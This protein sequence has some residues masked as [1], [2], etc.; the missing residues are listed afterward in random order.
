MDCK[1]ATL[2]GL[3]AVLLWAT[4]TGTIRG[5][6]EDLGP[7]AGA[8]AIYTL[9]AAILAV[10]VGRPRLAD[11]PPKYLFGAGGCYIL[12]QVCFVLALGF[13]HSGR[14]AIEAAML[15]YLWPSLTV[16]FAVLFLKRR[17]N[18]LIVPGLILAFAGVCW[19][20]SDGQGLL[21]YE[22]LGNVGDN[23]LC[24]G[25]AFVGS[26]FWAGYSTLAVKT[27]GG[28][29]GIALFPLLSAAVLWGLFLL[30]GGPPVRPSLKSVA[31]LCLAAAATGFGGTAWSV[32]IVRGNVMLL[33]V[34]SYF[35]PVLAAAFAAALLGA[36]L[37]APF[38]HGA[39]TVCCGS[40]L[41]WAS[42]RGR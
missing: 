10:A 14:Q 23:P 39:L 26:F 7:I 34:A 41:C 28:R 13:A 32:G 31:F 5:V 12:N 21:L 25:L 16:L 3:G 8:A 1:K 35:T 4:L 19:I 29:T 33:A 17:A 38:W 27:S 2:V 30:A 37:S 24:Y 6:S 22:L 11:Y 20:L 36:P 18:W 9:T 40:L 15:N 42:T